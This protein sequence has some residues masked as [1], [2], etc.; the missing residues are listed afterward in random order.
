[1][2]SPRAGRGVWSSAVKVDIHLVARCT[3]RH[4]FSSM[5]VHLAATSRKLALRPA[6]P[7]SPQAWFS[8]G[9]KA[10]DKSVEG[11]ITPFAWRY[12]INSHCLLKV[13]VDKKEWDASQSKGMVKD[14]SNKA[15]YSSYAGLRMFSTRNL[16]YLLLSFLRGSSFLSSTTKLEYLLYHTSPFSSLQEVNQYVRLRICS[17]LEWNGMD[18]NR[19]LQS[20]LAFCEK[21]QAKREPGD[22]IW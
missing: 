2:A 18:C 1:M 13:P 12:H 15:I 16:F 21:M 7:Q 9:S 14:F 6:I 22:S 3:F 20:K 8:H 17:D 11:S 19:Q 10:Y 5:C 4:V